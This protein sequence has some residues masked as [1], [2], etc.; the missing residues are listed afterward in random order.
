MVKSI[1]GQHID[2][3]AE[4]LSAFAITLPTIVSIVYVLRGHGTIRLVSPAHLCAFAC[5]AH[6]PFSFA[7]HLYRAFGSNIHIRTMLYKLDVIFIHLWALVTGFAWTFR[8]QFLETAYHFGCI[9]HII[10]CDPIHHLHEKRLISIKAAVG[11]LIGTFG[12][13]RCNEYLWLCATSAWC[14]AY[15]CHTETPFGAY[16]SAVMHILLVVPQTC[17]LQGLSS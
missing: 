4:I 1:T 15:I 17:L 11:V 12:L 6:F 7:L 8:Y 16:S 5:M 10:I 13:I 14:M 9:A 3:S 2:V